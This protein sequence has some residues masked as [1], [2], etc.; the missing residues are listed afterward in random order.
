MISELHAVVENATDLNKIFVKDAINKQ[1]PP[2]FAGAGDGERTKPWLDFILCFAAV[3]IRTI[4]DGSDRLFDKLPVEFFL[5]SPESLP[6]PAQNFPDVPHGAF[7][8]A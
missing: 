3:K 6:R 7:G 5:A 4:A 2:A 8:E 1:M